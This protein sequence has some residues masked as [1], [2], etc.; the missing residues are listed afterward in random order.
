MNKLL[1]YIY[2]SYNIFYH[3]LSYIS[4]S[5]AQISF[6]LYFTCTNIGILLNKDLF[7]FFHFLGM[8]CD[9]NFDC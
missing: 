9:F 5:F 6:V 4:L 8:L 1:W 2:N 7:N 3:L